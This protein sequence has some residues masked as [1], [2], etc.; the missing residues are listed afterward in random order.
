VTLTIAER[1]RRVGRDLFLSNAVT[2]RGGNLSVRD[3][4]HIH[5]TCRGAML[6][7]LADDDVVITLLEPGP[8]DAECSTELVVHRSVYL[9]TD[10]K[11]VVHAHPVHTTYR[12]LVEDEIHPIDSDARYVIGDLIPVLSPTSVIASVEA[13]EMLARVLATVPVAVLRGHGPFAVGPTIE[14][15]FAKVSILEAAC[16]ILDLRDA[17][18]APIRDATTREPLL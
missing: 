11:A 5:I 8:G 17:I 4:D 9:A 2:A 1:L 3:G 12:S 18:G 15:A 14:E 10:A 13:A 7:H 16:R 6:G